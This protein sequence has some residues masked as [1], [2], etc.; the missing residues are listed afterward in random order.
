MERVM[1]DYFL[2]L[3]PW[4]VSIW[5]VKSAGVEQSKIYK[6]THMGLW[7]VKPPKVRKPVALQPLPVIVEQVK[8]QQVIGTNGIATGLLPTVQA[9]FTWICHSHQLQIS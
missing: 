1:G 6:Y 3:N 7:I 4:K 9:V 5:L 8:K 2:L